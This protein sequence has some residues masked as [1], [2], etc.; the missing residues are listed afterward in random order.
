MSNIADSSQFAECLAAAV[1]KNVTNNPQC[2]SA[3]D[4]LAT[5]PQ[6]QLLIRTRLAEQ[7]ISLLLSR[8]AV[9]PLI[10]RC[11]CTIPEQISEREQQIL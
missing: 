10:G 9:Q 11:S 4:S 2:A 5:K 8:R 1:A 7:K 6:P 3:H